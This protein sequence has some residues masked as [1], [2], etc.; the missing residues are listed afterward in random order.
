MQ[1]K[2][3]ELTERI[4]KEGLEKG[5]AEANEI[6]SKA[7]T[8]AADIL[9][10]A[11]KEADKIIAD[12][13]KEADDYRKNVETEVAL[14]AKQVVSG[15]KQEITAMLE[16]KLYDAPVTDALKD[17]Q[18]VRKVIETAFKSWNPNS[19]DKVDLKVLVPAEMAG[20]I[21]DYFTGKATATLN[22]GLDIEVDKAIKYGFKIGP[23]DGGYLISFTDTDFENLFR[24]FMRPKIVALLFGGK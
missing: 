9:E 12:A 2:L 7:K 16:A 23:K 22:V 10:E 6:L 1:N 14:S 3:Q 11:R 24:D 17:A 15:L 5:Q 18:F 8:E 20:E 13:R 21:S 19:T 4:Y